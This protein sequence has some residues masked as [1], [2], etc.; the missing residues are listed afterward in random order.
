MLPGPL[1]RF[2]TASRESL[3]AQRKRYALAAAAVAVAAVRQTDG[4]RTVIFTA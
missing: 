1:K 3:W 4:S 2:S